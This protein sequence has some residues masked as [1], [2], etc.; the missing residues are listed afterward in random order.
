MWD[1][2]DEGDICVVEFLKEVS[3]IEETFH[4]QASINFDFVP[5]LL[6]EDSWI[7]IG[8]RSFKCPHLKNYHF[9]LLLY[10]KLN[11]QGIHVL[12]D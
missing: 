2:R 11:K 3:S 1:F 6:E 8:S 9:Y 10:N 12:H 4:C 5:I 7:P